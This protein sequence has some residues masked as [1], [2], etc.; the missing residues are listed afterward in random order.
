MW[1]ISAGWFP[2]LTISMCVSCWARTNGSS[3]TFRMHSSLRMCCFAFWADS[4]SPAVDVAADDD[5]VTEVLDVTRDSSYCPRMV[6]LRRSRWIRRCIALR[7]NYRTPEEEWGPYLPQ[8]YIV[9]NLTGQKQKYEIK[10]QETG[11]YWKIINHWLFFVNSTSCRILFMIIFIITLYFYPFIATFNDV[12]CSALPL[13]QKTSPHQWLHTFFSL[14][15][16]KKP[17][18]TERP[19][20]CK[21]PVTIETI[22]SRLI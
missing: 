3:H 16:L 9:K 11:R 2:S 13:T 15:F 5:T 14:F 1:V 4:F 20:P 19:R 6:N 8:N 10:H 22:T 21:L 17:G 18:D 12:E 7:D